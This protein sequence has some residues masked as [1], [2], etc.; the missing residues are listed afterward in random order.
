MLD[1]VKALDASNLRLRASTT[2]KGDDRSGTVIVGTALLSPLFL[3]LRGKDVTIPKGTSMMAYID[4]DRDVM[5]PGEPGAAAL[6][7]PVTQ[8][9]V[10]ASTVPKAD[11]ATMIFKSAPEGAEIIVDGMFLGNT[12]STIQLPASSHLVSLRKRA[13]ELW[14]KEVMTTPGGI[15]T[16]SVELEKREAGR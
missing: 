9:P 10:A 16:I 4:G 6:L 12:P 2:R 11:P 3:I 15:V 8:T 14:Q 7:T 13:Y 1:H 5:L